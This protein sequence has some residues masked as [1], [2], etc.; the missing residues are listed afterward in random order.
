MR[1][2]KI[3]ICL[4]GIDGAGKTLIA[5]QLIE[6]LGKSPKVKY[7]WSRYKNYFS[8][9]FLLLM[10]ITGHNYK[11]KINGIK[12]GYHD[13]YKNRYISII[14]LILQWFD[15]FIEILFRFRLEKKSIVSDRSLIDTLVDLV[16]DTKFEKFVFGFYAKSLFYLMPKNTTYLIIERDINLIKK[17]RPDVLYDKNVFKRIE[18]YNKISKLFSIKNI[19]NESSL[20]LATD[21]ILLNINHNN[22]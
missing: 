17:T 19:K 5:N 16:I 21:E 20:T 22:E 10:R 6:N 2:K 4:S 15:L 1:N 7:I 12:I 18:L 11:V 14:F 13:F 8:K 3:R 9:P